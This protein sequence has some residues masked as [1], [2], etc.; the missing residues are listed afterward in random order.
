M[1]IS[2]KAQ[3]PINVAAAVSYVRLNSRRSCAGR[4]PRFGVA[5]RGVRWA[6]RRPLLS[7]WH[8]V[9]SQVGCYFEGVSCCILRG[10]CSTHVLGSRRSEIPLSPFLGAYSGHCHRCVHLLTSEC[11]RNCLFKAGSPTLALV[12]GHHGHDHHQLAC[13]HVFDFLH[14]DLIAFFVCYVS[15]M[16]F[17]IVRT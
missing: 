14:R 4:P 16:L 13:V 15:G 10:S 9:A 17:V 2:F 12:R 1:G 5:S 3:L 7:W 8:G 6:C 11:S